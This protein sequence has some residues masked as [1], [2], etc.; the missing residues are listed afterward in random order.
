MVSLD[1]HESADAVY[2]PSDR[3]HR[4]RS[5]SLIWSLTEATLPGCAFYTD[6]RYPSLRL[7]QSH[8]GLNLNFQIRA[9]N[10]L[11]KSEFMA[12]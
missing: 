7:A 10:L 6:I 12:L 4:H 11:I 2:I 8:S 5:N 9:S 1:E 3:S